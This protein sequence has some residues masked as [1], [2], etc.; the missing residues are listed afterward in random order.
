MVM[1]ACPFPQLP[2]AGKQMVACSCLWHA[3]VPTLTGVLLFKPPSTAQSGRILPGATLLE[4]RMC[5]V[6]QGVQT[7]VLCCADSVRT[8]G[9]CVTQY[10]LYSI[11]CAPGAH[12]LRSVE[13]LD[14]AGFISKI[15]SML[16]M[17][18]AA[19]CACRLMM[20]AQRA[21]P[22]IKDRAAGTAG[23]GNAAAQREQQ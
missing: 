2:S 11:Q 22:A 17:V 23:Q 3:L 13:S 6:G 5:L 15:S 20:C 8:T 14:L 4:V 1:P 10:I 7:L 9:N 19:G 18:H 21:P 12:D 16:A